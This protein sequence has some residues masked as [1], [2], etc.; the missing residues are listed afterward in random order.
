M[1]KILLP[2]FVVWAVLASFLL[3][4]AQSSSGGKDLE[5]VLDEIERASG[6]FT[7]MEAEVTYTRSIVLLD[8]EDVSYGKVQYKKPKK[9]RMEFKSP[10]DEVD[11]A[12]GECLWIYH[13][14]G[15]QVEKYRLAKGD[16]KELDFFQFG[17]EGSVKTAKENY[18]IELVSGGGGDMPYILKLTPKE[19]NPPP[20]YSEIRLW[21]EEGPW[22]PVR[23][24]LYESG[25]EVINRIELRDIKLNK[26]LKESL[27]QFTVPEGVEVV[28][29]F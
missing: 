12:D 1:T 22:L 2:F 5:S 9:L 11:I 27:F 16:T 18:V 17:Y 3:L 25:G 19:M 15:K 10:K 24:E 26:T 20:Q 4:D 28:E 14:Q 13:P 21:I 7:S 29:P 23:M 6:N 8:E